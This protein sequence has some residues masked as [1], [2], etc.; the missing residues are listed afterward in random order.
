[1]SMENSR[2]G[3]GNWPQSGNGGQGLQGRAE[4][5]KDKV[6]NELD[7][8]TSKIA[9]SASAAGD[10]LSQ[11]MAKLREDMA[12]MQQTVS[13]FATEAG[14]EAYKTAKNVGNAVASQVSDMAGE[15]AA[16]A[17]DQAKTFAAELETMARRNPLGTIGATLL[18]GVV[19]G[20]MS[21]GRG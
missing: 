9:D 6:G 21:R 3:G 7:R 17:K 15:V 14:S 13:K 1:M 8:G 11:D 16:T 4:A 19:I 12:S 5:V 18:V 2:S 10:S 20:M